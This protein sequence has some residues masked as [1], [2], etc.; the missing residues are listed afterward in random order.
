MSQPLSGEERKEEG[1][2]VADIAASVA[3]QPDCS[4][5]QHSAGW[6]LVPVEPTEAMIEASRYHWGPWINEAKTERAGR[7]DPDAGERERAVWEQMLAAAPH[8]P[9]ETIWRPCTCPIG[10]RPTPCPRKY[11][12]TDCLSGRTGSEAYTAE[13]RSVREALNPL[14]SGEETAKLVERLQTRASN[15]ERIGADD[16]AALDRQAAALLTTQASEIE[17]L[18][19][20][21][22]DLRRSFANRNA[23]L[24]EDPFPLWMQV[25]ASFDQEVRR[26]HFAEATVASQAV[27]IAELEGEV[28]K[29]R[30]LMSTSTTEA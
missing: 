2:S 12:L 13:D 4:T 21:R 1:S 26:A 18:R 10:E 9:G 20:E 8:G 22:D 28:A 15:W 7:Y 16:H 27:R 29:L 5:A 6:R 17:R 24:P 3:S 25:V 11:A 23:L 30:R 19:G 14:L